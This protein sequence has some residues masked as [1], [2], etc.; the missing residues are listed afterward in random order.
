MLVGLLLA[1]T[2]P[3]RA[4]PGF[5]SVLFPYLLTGLGF[6]VGIPVSKAIHRPT[7]NRV[8]AA[9]KQSLLGLVVLDATAATA[10][11]GAAG[12]TILLF[13]VPIFFLNRYRWLYAT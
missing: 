6:L 2:L 13:L 10:F 7:P 8:Q 1:L 4:E 12:L 5:T 11:A 9:V 3:V